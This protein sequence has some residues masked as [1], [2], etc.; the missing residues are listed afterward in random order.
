M[1]A[2]TDHVARWDG[3][4]RC[5]LAHQRDRMCFARSEWPK[6]A[7]RPNIRVPCDVLF[8]GEAPGAVEDGLGL[9]FTGPAGDKLDQV[10]ERAL[11][12]DVTYVLTN[13]VL[14]FPREAKARGDNE[15]DRAEI[16]ACRPRLIEFANIARPKLTVC[17][18]ALAHHYVK[19]IC[20]G[21]IVHIVHPAHVLARMPQA[22][23]G[24]AFNKCV[25]QIRSAWDEVLQS[26]KPTST[27]WGDDDA[28][29]EQETYLP[30]F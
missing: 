29:V 30:E 14:C 22:Q 25:V 27:K 18:G 6:G 26:G 10:I 13:L 2:W 24:M 8:V 20:K 16:L 28:G 15:P 12:S 5:P 17:V 23:R 4:I 7:D 19:D 9:P 11:P 3:C 21:P 1:S